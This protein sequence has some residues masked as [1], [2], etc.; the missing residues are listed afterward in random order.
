MTQRFPQ[1]MDKGD[2][3]FPSP[4]ATLPDQQE[5]LQGKG[6]TFLVKQEEQLLYYCLH[7]SLVREAALLR[8]APIN[9]KQLVQCKCMC[10]CVPRKLG[11]W[12]IY[13]NF[14]RIV[15]FSLKACK[16]QHLLTT[17]CTQYGLTGCKS[18]YE[19][20]PHSRVVTQVNVFIL[21]LFIECL[22]CVR[23]FQGLETQ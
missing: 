23:L 21:R 22:L 10:F 13:K 9:R 17:H 5:T 18:C 16:F 12:F 14:C 11:S 1:D 8:E 20:I 2:R 3:S 4:P 7:G 19:K 15:Q 6:V